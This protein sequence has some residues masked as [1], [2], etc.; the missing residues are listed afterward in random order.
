VELDAPNF[1][2][3]TV[4]AY[5]AGPALH[6][7]HLASGRELPTETRAY[8]AVLAPIIAGEQQPVHAMT[9]N[10]LIA[11]FSAIGPSAES[12][13]YAMQTESSPSEAQLSSGLNPICVLTDSAAANLMASALQSGGLF[14]CQCDRNSQP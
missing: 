3:R 14:V 5:N 8:A 4:A 12:P 13:L 1:R 9:A 6:K 2:S 10:E 7:E 11:A